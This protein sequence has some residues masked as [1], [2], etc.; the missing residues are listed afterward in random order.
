MDD[1]SHGLAV[2]WL[3]N[4]QFTG[5]NTGG[6]TW[7]T[8][9]TLSTLITHYYSGHELSLSSFRCRKIS[10]SFGW[11]AVKS[12]SYGCRALGCSAERMQPMY[13]RTWLVYTRQRSYWR[14][15]YSVQASY[16]HSCRELAVKCSLVTEL[17]LWEEE[18]RE[19]FEWDAR[20][21]EMLRSWTSCRRI[22]CPNY[23]L[24]AILKCCSHK[25]WR[26]RWRS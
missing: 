16:L 2:R 13:R 4:L 14:H 25:S 3:L 12:L 5:S 20:F 18:K 21:M 7:S 22:D 10:T 26:A 11:G 8:R 15:N 6:A 19:K 9:L 24:H 1:T 23:Y 17:S